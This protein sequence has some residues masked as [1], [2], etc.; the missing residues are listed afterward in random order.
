ML[1]DLQMMINLTQMVIDHPPMQYI[2][3]SSNSLSPSFHEPP[4]P[5]PLL[6]NNHNM[7]T[8]AKTGNSKPKDFLVHSEPSTIKQALSKP[9]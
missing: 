8:R 9:D 2:S 1:F 6:V 7:L 4:L 3:D 5:H